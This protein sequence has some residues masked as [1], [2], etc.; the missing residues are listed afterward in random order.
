VVK[1]SG[2]QRAPDGGDDESPTVA[3]P[4]TTCA[5]D[6]TAAIP[7]STG[8][9][10][11]PA[12]SLFTS[13]SLRGGIVRTPLDRSFDVRSFGRGNAVSRRFVTRGTGF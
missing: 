11:I 7:H 2:L 9:M 3:L 6:R 8:A 1:Q 10:T 5:D 13:S 12:N 4:V